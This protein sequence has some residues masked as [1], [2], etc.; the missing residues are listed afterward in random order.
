MR[1]S[2]RAALVMGTLLLMSTAAC[3]GSDSGAGSEAATE[4]KIKVGGTTPKVHFVSVNLDQA[5]MNEA[6]R[7]AEAQGKKITFDFFPDAQL[8]KIPDQVENIQNGVFDAGEVSAPNDPGRMPLSDAFN[9][10]FMA[11]GAP[12]LIRAYYGALQ[13]KNSLIY[14]TDFAANDIVPLATFAN[15][16]YQIALTGDF[17]GF[18]SLKKAKLRSSGGGQNGIVE[19][20]GATPVTLTAA[21][22]Y[23]G[24]QR[25]IVDGGLFNTPSMIDNKTAEVLGSFTTNANLGSYNIAF[26]I[27]KKKWDSLPK[28][29]QDI[30]IEAGKT[31]TENIA[32]KISTIE[33]ESEERLVSEFGLKAVELDPT[34]IET[35]KSKMVNVRDAW[36]GQVKKQN[37]DGA[38]ALTEA[39]SAIKAAQ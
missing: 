28:W 5:L 38:A 32:T 6:T 33:K 17:K 8:G 20:L 31:T 24:L 4:V 10:P 37:V 36:V 23:E 2:K 12:T 25:K 3:G 18:D 34:Q 21:E 11:E 13:D 7:L 27:G 9:L 1:S 19:A 35:L 29:A 22:Q 39:E 15:T 16:D 30:L 14:K 26:A